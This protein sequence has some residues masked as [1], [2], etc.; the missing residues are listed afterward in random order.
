[1]KTLML[2]RKRRPFVAIAGA[3]SL[4]LGI[5]AA[6]QQPPQSSPTFRTEAELVIVDAV[7]VDGS[8]N[9]VPDLTAADFEVR[10]EDVPQQVQLFQTIA[11][12]PRTAPYD[13]RPRTWGWTHVRPEPSCSSST[14]CT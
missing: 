10:D 13:G 5:A 9:P 2:R 8:G 1:M 11:A 4:S 3:I 12:D 14:I 7:V 6:Q